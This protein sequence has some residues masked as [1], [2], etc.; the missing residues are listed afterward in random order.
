MSQGI[1]P[2]ARVRL[3]NLA[4]ATELNGV[5]GVVLDT[6]RGD[7][8]KVALASEDGTARIVTCR[9]ETLVPETSS[10]YGHPPT[11]IEQNESS[12]DESMDG[13]IEAAPPA[14]HGAPITSDATPAT[15]TVLCFWGDAR[16]SRTPVTGRDRAGALGHVPRVRARDVHAAPDQRRSGLEDRLVFAP[17]TA[18]TEESIVRARTQMRPL[19]EQA[20]LAAQ[21]EEG[22]AA[23]DAASPR[24]ASDAS[25]ERRRRPR[26]WA[27]PDRLLTPLRS[28]SPHAA[29]T[30]RAAGSCAAA[31]IRQRE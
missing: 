27:R 16:W 21:G 6:A 31:R 1:G 3:Q 7:R 29:A 28:K 22:D 25:N 10:L 14:E 23:E 13:G 18:M 9:P 30:P 26:R 8:W 12:D 2:G 11:P 24:R 20:R 4:T 5:L 15:G 17:V 19:R